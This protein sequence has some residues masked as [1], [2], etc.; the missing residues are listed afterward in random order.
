MCLHLSPLNLTQETYPLS[1]K[2][3]Q[4][5]TVYNYQIPLECCHAICMRQVRTSKTSKDS[6][7]NL[8]QFEFFSG[9]DSKQ[10]LLEYAK[11][12]KAQV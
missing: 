5:I 9:L 6:H 3:N 12:V 4:F 1:E 10:A 2:Y 7:E 8:S 11:H